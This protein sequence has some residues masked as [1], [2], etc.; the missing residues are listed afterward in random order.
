MNHETE[1]KP[2]QW[3]CSGKKIYEA[4]FKEMPFESL[5]IAAQDWFDDQAIDSSLW[6]EKMNRNLRKHEIALSN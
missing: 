3:D 4:I 5:P 6:S 1:Q 2:E